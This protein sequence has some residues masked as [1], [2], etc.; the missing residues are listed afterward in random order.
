MSGRAAAAPH[1]P[2]PEDTPE[3]DFHFRCRCGRTWREVWPLPIRADVLARRLKVLTC[4]KCDSH[5]ISFISQPD[6]PE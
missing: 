4:P 1:E 5:D 2:I 6:E 3:A